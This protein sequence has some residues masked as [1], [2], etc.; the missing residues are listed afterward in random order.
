MTSLQ[1]TKLNNSYNC[2]NSLLLS[3]IKNSKNYKNYLDI[4]NDT[5]F[6]LNHEIL[7]I[8]IDN[9]V[10]TNKR[11]ILVLL[12]CILCTL[13]IKSLSDIPDL[14]NKFDYIIKFCIDIKSS[15]TKYQVCKCIE[16]WI[17]SNN[18]KYDNLDSIVNVYMFLINNK[19]TDIH[20]IKKW[21]YKNNYIEY[22][23]GCMGGI[24][25]NNF[26]LLRT[27][28]FKLIDIIKNCKDPQ[29]EHS[30]PIKTFLELQLKNIPKLEYFADNIYNSSF[31]KYSFT[32]MTSSINTNNS[33]YT[34]T[35]N[36]DINTSNS[37]T[38][39]NSF[40]YSTSSS[41]VFE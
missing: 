29:I 17:N 5:I 41:I 3:K 20:S 28:F 40:N 34:S 25:L 26:V 2:I 33:S 10:S 35:C 27:Q 4:N 36:S 21:L 31:D 8:F 12:E 13:N 38:Y 32:E 14:F 11:I 39:D 24:T 1:Y 22:N 15:Y 16:I 37:D 6:N 23:I 9:N 30:E 18:I 7:N 19:Y